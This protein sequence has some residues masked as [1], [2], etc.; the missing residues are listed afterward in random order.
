M[1]HAPAQMTPPLSPRAREIAD[2]AHAILDAHGWEEVTMRALAAELG[3]KAPSLYKHFTSR[4]AIRAV[5]IADALHQ[6]GLA[7]HAATGSVHE[8]L[9]AY[10]AQATARPHLYRLATSGE[11]PRDQLP[12]GLEDWAGTPFFLVTGDPLTAQALWS[13]AHGTTMLELDNRYPPGSDLDALWA[14]GARTFTPAITP[15][16]TPRTAP[17]PAVHP[18]EAARGE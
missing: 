13:F 2:T 6:S 7:L 15:A 4:D 12:E 3:I 9:A 5:L 11:L 16:A 10:R 18:P 14:T 8:L 1:T 17:N